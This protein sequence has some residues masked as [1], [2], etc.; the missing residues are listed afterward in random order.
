MVAAVSSSEAR[1]EAKTS[2]SASSA[3]WLMVEAAG[4]LQLFHQLR[5]GLAVAA[6]GVEQRALEIRRHLNIHRRADRGAHP[7]GL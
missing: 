2:R 3:P 6:I 7:V 5:H 1:P 4:C